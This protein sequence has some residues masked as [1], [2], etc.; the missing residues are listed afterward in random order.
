HRDRLVIPPEELLEKR[1]L[2][3]R[4]YD[5]SQA[6]LLFYRII[7]NGSWPYE[8][9]L[10]FYTGGGNIG[11]WEHTSD[12]PEIENTRCLIRQMLAIEPTYR[13]DPMDQIEAEIKSILG[14]RV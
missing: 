6:G 13:V 1:P 3:Y 9:G 2:H 14:N 10:D 5:I 7:E 12:E 4:H 8:N 11:K